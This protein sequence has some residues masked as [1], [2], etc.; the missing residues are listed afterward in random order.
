MDLRKP[1]GVREH[2]AF[3]V[4]GRRFV[5]DVLARAPGSIIGLLASES[6]SR[7]GLPD[8]PLP[9]SIVPDRL[10]GRISDTVTSQGILAVCRLPDD[11]WREFEA[12]EGRCLV[13]VLDGAADPG[14]AGTLIRTA[15]AFGCPAVFLTPGSCE[16]FSPKVTRASAGANAF[17]PIHQRAE[18]GE[19]AGLLRS[20]GFRIL[21]AEA[22]GGALAALPAAPRVALVIGSESFG[23]SPLMLA[24][25]DGTVSIPM[26]GGMES[27][28][29][30]VAGSI[31]MYCV[32]ESMVRG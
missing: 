19:L 17:I 26:P 16:A 9:F 21:A 24:L 12:P 3:L 28:N 15:A 31:L 2:S 20:Q 29:A 23:I 10:L 27:L 22:G 4:E 13:P 14:N 11:R 5:R 18:P 8:S 1:E 32:K 7:E 25:C 30:A 6:A